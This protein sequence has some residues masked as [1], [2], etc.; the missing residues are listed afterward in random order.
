[1][2]SKTCEYGLQAMLYI[3]LYA[4]N[5]R[6]VGLKEIAQN[7]EIPSPFLSKILQLLVRNKIISSAK[8]PN[9]GFYPLKSPSKITLLEIVKLIDGTDI[10]N[11]C[12]IGLKKCSDKTPCP[13]HYEYHA[14]K[15]NIIQLLSGNSIADLCNDIKAG[16]A[17]VNFKMK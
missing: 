13:I 15:N 14:V 17:I 16:K 3:S 7:Q 11:Q 9:G 2:F 1:M 10:F 12:G 8:G 5:G 6:K 4:K